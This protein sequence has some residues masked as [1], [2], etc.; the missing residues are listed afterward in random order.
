[1]R[2][3][4]WVIAAT[5]A[6][7]A[8]CRNVETGIPGGSG[9][10]GS[11]VDGGMPGGAADGGGSADAGP[12]GGSD[13]GP[14]GTNDCDGLAPGSLGTMVTH[15][16]DYDSTSGACGL[17][18]GNG[19]GVMAHF[20]ANDAYPRFT[21]VNLSGGVNG[22]IAPVGRGDVIPL[23]GGFLEWSFRQFRGTN[24][25]QFIEAIDDSGRPQG[26]GRTFFMYAPREE[27]FAPD[28][29]GGAALAG[30]IHVEG[31]KDQHR[32]MMFDAT[33]AARWGPQELP[34]DSAVFGLGV[35][36]NGRALVIQAGYAQ[37]SG[38][39]LAQ[40]FERDGTPL[41]GSF[42]LLAGFS[43]GPATWFETAPL[44]DGG[45]AVRRMDADRS[46]QT[47]GFHSQWLLTVESGKDA[48]QAAPDWM[49]ARPDTN[50]ALA[51]ARTAYAALPNG[52]SGQQ[53]SQDLEL[54][55]RSGNSC[56]KWT[57]D[58][59]GSGTC[60]ALE[61]RLGLD[62]TILQRLPFELE[63]N[64]DGMGRTKTCTLR[65]WPTAL[66]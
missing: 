38:C 13:A 65:F 2:S 26:S 33:G 58:L 24:E 56:A 60:D 30:T 23:P 45:L 12:A 63:S 48:V 20:V 52:G 1:M 35:D 40:W 62:G 3:L 18:A 8:A 53:C 9:G 17:P 59:G 22:R 61:L 39:I 19:H 34:M 25:E 29:N 50:L 37:C 44:I 46:G 41:T 49:K 14:S 66:K 7:T 28:V 31:R 54:A 4:R 6:G 42:T 57:L 47:R 15:A 27:V 43:A 51:R 5:I 21:L 32:V 16:E 36:L 64:R 10:G 11:G 55:S